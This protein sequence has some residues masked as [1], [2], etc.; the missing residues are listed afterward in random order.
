MAPYT[1]TGATLQGLKRCFDGLHVGLFTREQVSRK[2]MRMPS[3]SV[4]DLCVV[5]NTE[6]G[7]KDVEFMVMLKD[8]HR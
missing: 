6:C 2:L 3:T 4:R 5:S 7:D 8:I 1:Y